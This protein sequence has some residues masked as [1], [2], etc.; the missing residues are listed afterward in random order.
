M[1]GLAAYTRRGRSCTDHGAQAVA[2]RRRNLHHPSWTLHGRHD[3]LLHCSPASLAHLCSLSLALAGVIGSG[4]GSGSVKRSC[5]S[6]RS[7]ASGSEPYSD[8]D[9]G[10]A[11]KR[12]DTDGDR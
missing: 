3:A 11:T 8:D 1:E 10:S 4:T 7:V 2:G 6:L 12:G 5:S 9:G